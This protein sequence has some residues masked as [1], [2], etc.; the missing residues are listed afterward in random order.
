MIRWTNYNL[1]LDFTW[2]RSSPMSW[3]FENTFS[4][5]SSQAARDLHA[6][7]TIATRV[8][9]QDPPRHR[10]YDSGWREIA[11]DRFVT[12]RWTILEIQRRDHVVFHRF[13]L[14]HAVSKWTRLS[15]K[16]RWD[17]MKKSW[18]SLLNLEKF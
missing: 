3:T 5:F 6:S 8:G 9:I 2:H 15:S 1:F 13:I 17:E 7:W 4:T 14:V 18:A 11:W 12:H 10:D 16:I